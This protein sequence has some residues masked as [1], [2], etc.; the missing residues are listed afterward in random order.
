MSHSTAKPSTGDP[1]ADPSKSAGKPPDL[2]DLP[3][4]EAPSAGFVVQLFVIPAAVV[5]VVII[6]WLLFGKLA[7]GERDPMEYVRQLRLPAANWRSAFELASLIQNEPSIASDPKLVG[8][9]TDL[10]SHELDRAEDPK[11]QDD[12]RLAQYLALTMG[13]FRTLEGQTLSGQVV[14][15]IDPLS[16]ALGPKFDKAIRISAAAS[17]AKQAAREEGKLDDPR[18]V[19]ALAAMAADENP[20]IRQIAVYALGFFAG[21]EAD[22]A[23]RDRNRS[24]EDRF[25]RYNAAVA[26]GRR[27]DPA[28]EPTLRE[29]LTTA[30][31]DKVVQVD[32]QTKEQNTPAARQNS[33]ETIQLEAL[34]AVRTS[35][36][37]SPPQLARSLRPEVEKLTTS[38]LVSVRSQATELLHAVDAVR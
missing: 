10:F 35:L 12:P 7:G 28:A 33:I 6:V 15:P 32:P 34:D 19:K 29:M 1:F 5:V 22:Q 23:L 18:A 36:G 37:K 31:L 30:D 26:L 9:L 21:P 16:R 20:Q 2:P 38:G 8:E 27:G 25:T 24:D 3:P 14:D 17:L 11:Q 13:S 4:V